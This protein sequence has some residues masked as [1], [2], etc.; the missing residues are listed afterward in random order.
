MKKLI[1][2]ASIITSGIIVGALVRKYAQRGFSFS[3]TSTL[4][5]IKSVKDGIKTS[6]VQDDMNEFFV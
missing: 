3:K 2:T 6:L 4:D 1:T 5:S